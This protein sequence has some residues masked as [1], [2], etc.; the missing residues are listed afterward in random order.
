MRL[1]RLLVRLAQQPPRWRSVLLWTVWLFVIGWLL[2]V[3]ITSCALA[4]PPDVP[5]CE[6][7]KIG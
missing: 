6:C 4:G 2:G 5:R 3:I 1:L 7:F